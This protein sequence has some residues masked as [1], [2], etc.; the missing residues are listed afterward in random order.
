MA[1]WAEKDVAAVRRRVNALV[2]R[3]PE[4]VVE[5]T[6]GHTGYRLRG[7]RIVWLVADHHGDG[8]LAIW[9]KAPKGEQEALV[10]G[11]SKRY[12]VP[13]YVGPSGWIGVNLDP[14][15]KPD[16]DEIDALLEQAWRMT[17][18]KRAIAAFDA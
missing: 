12:F 6:H 10:G 15:S 7:R 18:T 13:P 5:D 17:A 2:E 14:P 3:L 9:V 4:V 16:W 1:D 8:R 11:D